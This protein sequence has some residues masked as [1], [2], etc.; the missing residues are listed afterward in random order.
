MLTWTSK[1]GS[2]VY[3][4]SW[5]DVPDKELLSILG[6]S[7]LNIMWATSHEMKYISCDVQMMGV[8]FSTK[9]WR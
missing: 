3:G 5:N 9:A 7:I 4:K 1:E 2:A 8:Q 6:L